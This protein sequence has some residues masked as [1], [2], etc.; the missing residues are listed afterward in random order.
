LGVF[1]VFSFEDEIALGEE[2]VFGA[3]A[4]GDS[5]AGFGARASGSGVCCHVLFLPIGQ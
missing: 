1:L 5:F 2:A 3:V 4:G